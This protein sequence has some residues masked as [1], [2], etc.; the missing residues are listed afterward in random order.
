MTYAKAVLVALDQ[1]VDAVLGGW[2]DE[3]VSSRFFDAPAILWLY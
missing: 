3:T 1:L 2:P